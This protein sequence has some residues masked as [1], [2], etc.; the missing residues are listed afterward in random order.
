MET[1]V[2][3]TVKMKR[4][5]LSS[6]PSNDKTRPDSTD[7]LNYLQDQC[8]PQMTAKDLWLTYYFTYQDINWG[9]AGRNSSCYLKK[10]INMTLC[11]IGV[12]GSHHSEQQEV[13]GDWCCVL[14]KDDRDKDPDPRCDAISWGRPLTSDLQPELTEQWRMEKCG[15]HSLAFF[16][17][18][19][20]L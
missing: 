11:P 17:Y 13:D 4:L 18:S 9:V 2:L 3:I 15:A 14:L 5:T 20:D 10:I 16:N 8:S 6:I 12:T 7:R 19:A 1:C